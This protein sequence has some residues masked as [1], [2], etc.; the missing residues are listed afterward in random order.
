M[1]IL[2]LSNHQISKVVLGCNNLVTLTHCALEPLELLSIMH[3]LV[4]I[5]WDSF[6]G[7]TSCVHVAYIQLKPEDISY[8]NVR[9]STNIGTLEGIP[10]LILHYFSNLTL[11]L[12]LL[13]R[14]LLIHIMFSITI[15]LWFS[16]ISFLFIP[17]FP[18][19]LVL[20]FSISPFLSPCCL[21]LHVCSYEVATTVC[22]RAPCNK[23]LI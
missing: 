2:T 8:M 13:V 22:P 23:L 5:V 19:S 18:F 4:N 3:P 7:R 10:L 1:I 15:F 9:G 21:S 17:L 20:F 16:L 6:L 11:V 14:S 12:F